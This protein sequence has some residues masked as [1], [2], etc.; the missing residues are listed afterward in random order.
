MQLFV[1][2]TKTLNPPQE[3]L[4]NEK[5]AVGVRKLHKFFFSNLGRC[6]YVQQVKSQFGELH[7][8]WVPRNQMCLVLIVL[9]TLNNV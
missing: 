7:P 6:F 4:K 5:L 2:N 8:N 9:T 1:I 3:K